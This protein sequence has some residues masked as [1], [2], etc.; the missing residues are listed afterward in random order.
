M[1][2]DGLAEAVD[3]LTGAGATATTIEVFRHYYGQLR[4]G[5]T[6][7][8]PETSIEPLSSPVRL[9]DLQIDPGQARDALAQT[10]LIKLNG[11]L[12]TSM[13]MSKAKS[14]VEVRDGLSFLDIVVRQV[15]A[16][17][18]RHDIALPLLLMNS[19]NTADDTREALS[20]YPELPVADLPL[21]FMQSQEPKLLAAD[22]TPVSWPPDP[23]L[24]W[25][26]PGHGDLYPSLLGSGVLDALLAAGFRYASVSNSDN[27]G[28]G[29]DARLAGWF[30]ASGA[31]FAVEVCP[32]TP[33]DRKGGHLAVRRSDGRLILREVAQTPT[34]DLE[35]FTDEQR[36]PY[37]N[38]NNLWLDLAQVR[39]RLDAEGGVLGLPL[40]RNTKPVDPRDPS[41]PQVV[42]IE[43]A[44]GAAIEVFD[45]AQAIAVP[46]SRFLPVK[47]TNELLLVRSDVYD[48]ATDGTLHLRAD[49]A[50]VITLAPTFYG[51]I[52]DFDERFAAG[53]PS[54][55]EA[56]S[57]TVDGD[58]SFLA[59]TRV[60][61]AV[62][63]PETARRQVSSGVLTGG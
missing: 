46:R 2:R 18:R 30:A 7:L 49:A 24:E 53:V 50:P 36:H 16:A 51:R 39:A 11:G 21:D 32:R 62:T 27:L 37:F 34:D 9:D 57:F 63:L 54:L 4:S 41:S 44:M 42:Q 1:T 12:G 3:K 14:L 19:F 23:Q 55:R 31:P 26:P 60:V 35:H 17:R 40:I 28:A 6:G 29:P 45:G 48:L 5:A 20:C 47:T 52:S 13:G 58:Y 33:M 10:V 43:T 25:C 38:T 61:G 59:D 22:L 15:L 56:T 8:I